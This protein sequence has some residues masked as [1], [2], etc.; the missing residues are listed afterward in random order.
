MNLPS[1]FRRLVSGF[2][3]LLV[4]LLSG[5]APQS[6][7]IPE[8]PV[9][10]IIVRHAEKAAEPADDPPLTDDGQRR[11]ALLARLA[12][13][14]GASSVYATQ[15]LRTQQTVG[16]LAAELGL[17]IQQRDA[18]DVDGLVQQ[19]LAENKGQTV[20]IAGHSNTVPMLVEKLTGNPVPAIEETEYD[21]L[22]VVSAWALGEGTA[23]R[24]RYGD[25]AAQ[26]AP[27]TE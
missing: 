19:I 4:A 10:A 11:A 1:R 23:L 20:V 3:L 8:N 12:G 24:L 18:G 14:S 7:S 25:S 22:Y 5:C 16:P 9:T 6:Q 13:S 17:T 15:Y 21:N 27:A 2:A 26:A